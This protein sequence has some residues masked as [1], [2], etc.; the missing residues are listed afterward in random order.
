MYPALVILCHHTHAHTQKKN[1]T[2]LRFALSAERFTCAAEL[3]R[4]AAVWVPRRAP[5]LTR[6]KSPCA[7][8]RHLVVS[9]RVIFS[10][11]SVIA[12][13]LL[14]ISYSRVLT[15]AAPVHALFSLCCYF[16]IAGSVLEGWGVIKLTVSF[17]LLLIEFLGLGTTTVFDFR[18]VLSLSTFIFDY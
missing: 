14:S 18:F 12:S 8:P 10:P 2:A 11:L 16:P 15:R 3:T 5:L 9:R 1:Y 6:E 7:S 4:H 17:F 13:C